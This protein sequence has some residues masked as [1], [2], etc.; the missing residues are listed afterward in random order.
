[1]LARASALLGAPLVVVGTITEGPPRVR[2]LD[3]N[4]R[5]VALDHEG[6]DHLKPA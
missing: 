6:W 2:V 4:G 3:A 1:V 5:D